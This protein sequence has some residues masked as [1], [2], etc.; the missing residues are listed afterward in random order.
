MKRKYFHITHGQQTLL[1]EAN[2]AR[3]NGLKDG[4]RIHSAEEFGRICSAHAKERMEAI[5]L[6]IAANQNKN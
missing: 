6:L 4:Q 1:V 3:A 5:K 2:F